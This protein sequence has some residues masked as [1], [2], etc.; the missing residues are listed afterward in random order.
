MEYMGQT[1]LM[2]AAGPLSKI[3]LVNADHHLFGCPSMHQAMIETK[4]QQ[5]LDTQNGS[6]CSCMDHCQLLA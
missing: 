2:T 1:M 6:S 4:I 5:K 3:Q